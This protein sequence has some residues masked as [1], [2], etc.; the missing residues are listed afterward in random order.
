MMTYFVQDYSEW[1][2]VTGEPA[3][4]SGDRFEEHYDFT[5]FIQ[6]LECRGID[7]PVELQGELYMDRDIGR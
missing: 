6:F 1:D 5:K 2:E 4:S 3:W 7:L